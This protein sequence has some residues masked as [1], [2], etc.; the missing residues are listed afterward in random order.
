M[1]SSSSAP[2]PLFVDSD[3]AIEEIRQGRILIVVDDEQRENEGDLVMAAEFATPEKIAFFVRHTSG[4]I[5]VSMPAER[6]DALH[7]PLMVERNEESFRTAFTDSVDL[8]RGVTTG[9][10]AQDRAAT[11][12]AL[13]D[14]AT[15][16]A[17]LARPGHIFPL[18]ARPGG[19]LQRAGH[20]EAA[21]DLA[22]LAGLHPVGVLCELVNED[23]TM[24]RLPDLRR[25]A[26]AH[27]LK[28]AT[29]RDLIA[30]RRRTEELIRPIAVVKLPTRV[31]EFQLKAFE[32]TLTREIHLALV[33]GDVSDGGA[34]LVR[35]HSECLTGD[36][37]HSFRCDC[38]DQLETSMEMIQNEGRGVLLYMRQEGRGIGLHAKLKAYELQ[39]K[40]LDTVEAN[41]QLGFKADLRDYGIGAQILV[42]L[43]V[44]RIRLVTNNP[45]KIIGLEGYGLSVVER[46]PIQECVRDENRRYLAAKRE[47]LGHLL[48]DLA[49]RKEHP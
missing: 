22:R 41:E 31:G 6:C 11:I 25:F 49:E 21:V 34:V 20:T 4:V 16:P 5:C 7:L 26:E 29:I 12:R 17:D 48:E 37:F 13:A 39:E 46:V 30:H 10:S 14:P 42:R 38:G 44:K 15:K 35:V 3:G 33:K 2:A 43:G 8:A 1:T 23:G 40:G 32:E 36:L 27:G 9:I 47:K 18:R 19:V 45:R 24:S 28:I